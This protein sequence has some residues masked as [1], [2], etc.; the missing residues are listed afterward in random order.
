MENRIRE[1]EAKRDVLAEEN[2]QLR[3]ALAHADV[4]IFQQNAQL[5]QHK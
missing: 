2:A 5:T 3:L 4:I 1:L